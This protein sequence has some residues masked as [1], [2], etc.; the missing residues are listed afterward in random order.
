MT[1]VSMFDQNASSFAASTD[2][3]IQ[4]NVYVRGRRF[5]EAVLEFVPRGGRIVD[6]GC[7][8]GRVAL[9]VARAGYEV[10]GLD[11]SGSM[12]NEARRLETS[13]LHLRFEIWR[14]DWTQQLEADQYDGIICSS[15]IEYIPDPEQLLRM[16]HRCLRSGGNLILS[17][18][19][20]RSVWGAYAKWRFG[21]SA[22]HYKFQHNVWDFGQCRGI[23]D[24]CGF[25]IVRPPKFF[26]SP[27]DGRP[28]LSLFA[29]SPM[30]GTLGIVIARRRDSA[31]G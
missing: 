24:R 1:G 29:G 9:L 31:S 19:N 25:D 11:P 4:R 17:Y 2:E 8:P 6:Y 13:R 7:G 28:G 22:F 30:L 15:V 23:L 12:I 10:T 18:A 26:D 5:V 21:R 27:F 14:G 16:F 3:Q 20:S